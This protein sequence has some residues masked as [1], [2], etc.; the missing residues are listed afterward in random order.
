MCAGDDCEEEGYEEPG[1]F[2]SEARGEWKGLGVVE[3]CASR[4]CCIGVV[5]ATRHAGESLALRHLLSLPW[6]SGSSRLILSMH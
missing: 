5:R 3:E 2:P 4:C 6:S 1:A